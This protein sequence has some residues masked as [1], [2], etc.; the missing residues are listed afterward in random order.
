MLFNRKHLQF[1]R[2][3]QNYIEFIHINPGTHW[4][5]ANNHRQRLEL[6]VSVQYKYMLIVVANEKH[7]VK[8]VASCEHWVLVLGE[9][10]V[11]LSVR[12]DKLT[13]HRVLLNHVTVTMSH[14]HVVRRRLDCVPC[15][16]RLEV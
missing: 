8:L 11:V 10:P 1:L 6:A 13:V 9:V 15:V 4:M 2:A 14:K 16:I 7:V 5:L 3:P 12:R